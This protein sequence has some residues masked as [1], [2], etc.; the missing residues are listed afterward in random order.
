MTMSET[1]Q[2]RADTT[3]Q[4]DSYA[5]HRS[6]PSGA[7]VGWIVFAG[8]MMIMMGAFQGIAGLVAIFKDDYFLVPNTGLVVTVDYT[9][10]GWVHLI[11]GIIAVLAGF[12][13]IRGQMWA[14]VIGVIIAMASAIVNLGFLSAYPIWS[15]IM[16]TLDVIVIY[17]LIVHGSEVKSAY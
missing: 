15:T 13:V 3:V 10:W 11:L 5:G 2:S 16:I 1:Q 4:R 7:W 6:A 9:A 8:V 12:A 17:A 14:R